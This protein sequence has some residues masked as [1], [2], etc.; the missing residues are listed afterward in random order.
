VSEPSAAAAAASCEAAAVSSGEPPGVP[1]VTVGANRRNE[2]GAASRAPEAPGGRPGGAEGEGLG[3]CSRSSARGRTHA[4]VMQSLH[5]RSIGAMMVSFVGSALQRTCA[6]L[7][8]SEHLP[9][10]W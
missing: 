9:S 3:V 1:I 4:V 5:V 2:V 8:S 6:C 10:L 7:R